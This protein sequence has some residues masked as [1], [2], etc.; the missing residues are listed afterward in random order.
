MK[1][2]QKNKLCGVFAAAMMV[3]LAGSGCVNGDGSVNGGSEEFSTDNPSVSE[4]IVTESTEPGSAA[5]DE[6]VDE[7]NTDELRNA[8][9]AELVGS[10]AGI[11]D[12]EIGGKN[13]ES[14]YLQGYAAIDLDEVLSNPDKC[15][16]G[17]TFWL[18]DGDMPVKDYH[19]FI[20][21]W[22]EN[23]DS[24]DCLYEQ[25]YFPVEVGAWGNE[26]TDME[27]FYAQYNEREQAENLVLALDARFSQRIAGEFV[28]TFDLNTRQWIGTAWEDLLV[29][30]ILQHTEYGAEF[31]LAGS[32]EG[33]IYL[34][35]MTEEKNVRT[36]EFWICEEGEEPI[37][38]QGDNS[39]AWKQNTL[40]YEY[41]DVTGT[42][43]LTEEIKAEALAKFE[44]ELGFAF[45]V[46]SNAQ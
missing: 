9:L 30:M 5:Q 17:M 20:I 10:A 38:V 12:S 39:K 1:S 41:T 19:K 4:S 45:V 25:I 14:L 42:E 8:Y 37:K 33:E 3:C 13:N 31:S 22:K 27:R 6:T 32:F 43:A 28:K 7:I 18:M 16:G 15:V 11:F 24:N 2:K 21:H 35:S 40:T 46:S 44:T 26:P 34:T 29:W 36:F 23:R